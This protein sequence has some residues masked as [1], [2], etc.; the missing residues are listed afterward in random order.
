MPT[1]QGLTEEAQARFDAMNEEGISSL[2]NVLKAYAS[3]NPELGYCQSMNFVV[4]MLLFHMTEE[5]AFWTLAALI[6][7]ILP[8]DYY[9]QT[10]LGICVDQSVFDRCVEEHMPKLHS[11]L[12]GVGVVRW[13]FHFPFNFSFQQHDMTRV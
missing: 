4:M 8:P 9:S 3:R 5:M 7:D 11:H 2:R 10:M 1:P 13:S 6:E 12:T